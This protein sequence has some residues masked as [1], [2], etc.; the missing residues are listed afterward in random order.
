MSVVN[1]GQLAEIIGVSERTITTWQKNG[2]PIA[3]DGTRG[4]QNLYQTEEVIAWMIQRELTQRIEQFGGDEEEFFNYEKENARLTHHKAN[5][6]EL[7]ES[8]KRRELIPIGEVKEVEENIIAGG[9]AKLLAI[10]KK[11]APRLLGLENL[12]QAEAV[13]SAGVR[14][15]AEELAEHDWTEAAVI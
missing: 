1:K 10:P 7:E 12:A 8:A 4:N 3:E 15:V 13:L 11:L 5:L 2:L 9:R 14:E 6:A